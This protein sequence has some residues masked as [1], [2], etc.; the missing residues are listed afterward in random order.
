MALVKS[1]LTGA[2]FKM[3]GA[4]TTTML[5]PPPGRNWSP[6]ILTNGAEPAP[7]A[8]DVSPKAADT[9]GSKLGACAGASALG[10]GV[11]PLE[12]SFGVAGGIVVCG[13][14]GGHG[15]PGGQGTPGTMAGACLGCNQP[16]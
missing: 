8:N 4:R 15:A 16:S 6:N 11:F 14:I 3:P 12:A 1:A 9:T 5:L 2:P 7:A 13:V 10:A